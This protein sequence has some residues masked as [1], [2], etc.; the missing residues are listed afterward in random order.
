MIIKS[1]IKT[2]FTHVNAS[3]ITAMGTYDDPN[4][5]YFMLTF[6]MSS[7]NITWKY[8]DQKQRD[9]KLAEAEK[10]MSI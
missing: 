10:L 1:D 8:D 2:E 6:R 9:D 7:G 5:N 4:G 3:H